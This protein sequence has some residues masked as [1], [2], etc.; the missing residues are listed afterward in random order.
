MISFLYG[1]VS[2]SVLLTAQDRKPPALLNKLVSLGTISETQRQII[3]NHLQTQISNRFE[4]ISQRRFDEAQ[5]AA[6]EELDYDECTE[7]NCVRFIQDALQ[8]ENFFSLQLV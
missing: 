1:V 5:N 2:H 4:L 3:F 6:F 8:V 7:E